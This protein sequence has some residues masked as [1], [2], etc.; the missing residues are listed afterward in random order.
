ME[1]ILNVTHAK[2]RRKFFKIFMRVRRSRF[3]MG[4]QRDLNP[5]ETFARSKS[6]T[7]STKKMLVRAP[8]VNNQPQMNPVLLKHKEATDILLR[9]KREIK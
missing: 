8:G 3:K 9:E 6:D 5:T 1:A 2:V 7:R 4:G